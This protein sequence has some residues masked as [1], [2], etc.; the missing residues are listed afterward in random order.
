MNNKQNTQRELEEL[1]DPFFEENISSILVDMSDHFETGGDV[2]RVEL[3]RTRDPAS[4]P[5]EPSKKLFGPTYIIG[6]IDPSDLPQEG[7]DFR[8]PYYA[9]NSLADFGSVDSREPIKDLIVEGDSYYFTTSEGQ[10]R[11]RVL[12]SG[13]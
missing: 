3:C 7:K 13:N 2:V 5:V 12:D 6:L 4:G 8:M 11:L 9:M 1:D 10:W